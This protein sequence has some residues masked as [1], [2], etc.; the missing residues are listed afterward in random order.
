[1]RILN[2]NQFSFLFGKHSGEL[3]YVKAGEIFRKFGFLKE[4]LYNN[5]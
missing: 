1:M 5:K 3:F 4:Y 2:K